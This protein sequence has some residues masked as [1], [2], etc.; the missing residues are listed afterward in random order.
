MLDRGVVAPL[1]EGTTLLLADPSL[2]AASIVARL[3]ETLCCCAPVVPTKNGF[4]TPTLPSSTAVGAPRRRSTAGVRVIE[5]ERFDS[6]PS[7]VE[8]PI[9]RRQPASRGCPDHQVSF[10]NGAARGGSPGMGLASSRQRE[11]RESLVD[12]G[13]VYNF[14][15]TARRREEAGTTRRILMVCSSTR[16]ATSTTSLLVFPRVRTNGRARPRA[17]ASAGARSR[18]SGSRPS[19]GM[20]TGRRPASSGWRRG[21]ALPDGHGVE[22]RGRR[23]RAPDGPA[24]FGAGARRR[25]PSRRPACSS[26]SR[27]PRTIKG[28]LPV[29]A[30]VSLLERKADLLNHKLEVSGRGRPRARVLAQ[31]R[32]PGRRGQARL[33]RDCGGECAVRE[34]PGQRTARG[35]VSGGEGRPERRGRLRRGRAHQKHWS[36]R[37]HTL[38]RIADRVPVTN[39][40]P[41]HA[42][43]TQA[44]EARHLYD[45]Y[46]SV[47]GKTLFLPKDRLYLTSKIMDEHFDFGVLAEHKVVEQ[48]LA[49]HDANAGESL[50]LEW[51]SDHWVLFWRSSIR[52]CARRACP[53]RRSTS[54]LPVLGAA[55]G[56]ALMEVRAYFGEQVALY[57][58]WLGYY[59]YSLTTPTIVLT[60]AGI[61]EFVRRN[62]RMTRAGGSPSRFPWPSS[63]WPGRPLYKDGWDVEQQWCA[64]KW[65]MLDFEEE[66][67]DRPQFVGDADEPRRLSPITNQNETYYP[68]EKRARTQFF[69]SII[70]ALLALLILVIFALIFELSTS[71]VGRAAGVARGL[72]LAFASRDPDPVVL[73]PVQPHRLLSERVGEL[74]DADELR[75]QPGAEGVRL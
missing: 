28:L 15:A 38:E 75:Q 45:E 9:S 50:T 66:E 51:F 70:V 57:F 6:Q 32:G 5:P 42:D 55:V 3:P 65:G 68:A 21:R 53:C 67:Q 52:D 36:R 47:R 12:G 18:R 1:D 60:A 27:S 69:N 35:F 11:L 46:P 48:C 24:G 58:A 63:S 41:A 74:P 25:P 49:L 10:I 73:A 44:P 71:A 30:P 20:R 2:V 43:F 19:P 64:T 39:R 40:F 61:Y 54:S 56:P 13:A 14:P 26:S 33:L 8:R 17:R 7:S 23:H 72:R 62:Q 59:G 31:V 4:K 29:R 16:R 22:R 37:V 34:E